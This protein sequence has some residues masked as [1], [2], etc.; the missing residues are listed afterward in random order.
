[1]K[2]AL[3]ALV[4]LTTTAC[5]NPDIGFPSDTVPLQIGDDSLEEIGQDI[6]LD[7]QGITDEALPETLD[8]DEFEILNSATIITGRGNIEIELFP[9][10]TP[11]TV[12]NFSQKVA[13]GF[14]QGLIF[15]RVEDWVVQ[16]GDPLGDGTGGGTMPT[17]LTDR[18]FLP[19]SVGVARGPDIRISNDAQFFICKTECSHL[20]GQY[21]IFGQVTSGM[22]TVMAL[23]IGDVIQSITE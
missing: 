23:E 3:L 8:V 15:H 20:T 21:T 18:P 7:I 17:E 2:L 19:G 16:G 14:Y 13:D 4:I 22:D 5:S 12:A 9:E 11:Q 1:M 10:E 6:N